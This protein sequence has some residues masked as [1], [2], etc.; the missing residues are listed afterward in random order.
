MKFRERSAHLARLSQ[1]LRRGPV[2]GLLGARQVGKTTLT[3]ELAARRKGPTTFF[4]L[5]DP[6]DLAQLDEP[7]LALEG[8]RGLVVLD[9]I[10]HRPEIFPV[11][12]VLADRP[13]TPAR[14]LVLGSASPA[15]LRQSAE[16]LAGRIAYHELGGFDLEEVGAESLDRLWFRGGFP[17]SFL[18]RSH[19]ESAEW[20]R[21]F[22][23]TFLARDLP[24]L[25]ITLPAP[26]LERFWT[27]LAHYHGQVW[28]AS[29][30]ARS[31]GVS[32]PTVRRYLDL[33][34]SVFV[35]HVLPPWAENV[36]KR[37]VKSPKVYLADSGL[38]HAL[39][40]LSTIQDLQ[41]HPKLGS[42]WEGFM[43][44]QV[45]RTLRAWREECFFW[46][47]HAGAELDLLVV[48]GDRRLGFEIKRTDSPRVTASMRSAL[49]TLG[50]DQLTVVHA[51]KRSFPLGDKVVALAATNVVA[52]LHPLRK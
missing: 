17:R 14:F 2:V 6:R 45:I 33:L 40:G 39:L 46:A 11:L 8:L 10:Q 21:D 20:R 29:E 15:L 42:S 5:E 13:R 7:T 34:S 30:F 47:T 22:I 50:L 28:N 36:G 48:T 16:S 37:V 49:Q 43:L 32:Q 23:R 1:L 31:F 41:R 51:G 19:R 9:E 12:R 38:L 44:A 24:Q 27:M 25:G 35:M 26:T 4:D 18:A 52:A 3:R